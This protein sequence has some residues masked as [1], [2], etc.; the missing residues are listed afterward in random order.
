MREI[1]KT[2]IDIVYRPEQAVSKKSTLDNE[3]SLNKLLFTIC[4]YLE[5]PTNE[6]L[7]LLQIDDF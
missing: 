2:Y 5:I 6:K 3:N 1:A 4:S 7:L